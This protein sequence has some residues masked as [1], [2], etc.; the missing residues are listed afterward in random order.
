MRV[1]F[2]RGYHSFDTTIVFLYKVSIGLQRGS[3]YKTS[4]PLLNKPSFREKIL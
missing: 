1:D 3:K 2:Q 4:C